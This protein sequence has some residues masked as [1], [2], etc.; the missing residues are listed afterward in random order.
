[1]AQ[2]REDEEAHEHPERAVDQRWSTSV[3]LDNV[4]AGERH[5]EVHG[6]QDDRS[7]VW[8][9]DSNRV[10]DRGPVVEVVVCASKLLQCLKR[11]GE[12]CTVQHARTSEDLVPRVMVTSCVLSL[13]FLLNLADFCLHVRVIL[14]DSIAE[15]EGVARTLDLSIAVLPTWRFL[16]E[17]DTNDHQERPD[18]ANAHGDLPCARTPV[19]FR[20]EVDAIRD[21]DSKRDEQLVAR[22]KGATDVSRRGLGLI[23]GRENRKAANAETCYPSTERDLVPDSGGGNLNNDADAENDVPEDDA[24][25]ASKF[26]RDGRS[27]QCTYQGT[28]GEL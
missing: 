25:L 28:D 5:A 26:I 19:D 20:A 16:H 23:H 17:Q 9:R 3:L 18:E 22:H 8:V 1:V 14:G 21:E 13:E 15:C 2:R 11:D 7:N 4:E 27:N 24:V 10:E 6:A 12:K